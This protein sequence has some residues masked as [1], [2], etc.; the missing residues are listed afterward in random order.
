M[1][2]TGRSPVYSEDEFDTNSPVISSRHGIGTGPNPFEAMPILTNPVP[3]PGQSVPVHANQRSIFHRNKSLSIVQS[4]PIRANPMPTFIPITVNSLP[5]LRQHR[6]TLQTQCQSGLL[7]L[8]QFKGHPVL[9]L[10]QSRSCNINLEHVYT[11]ASKLKVDWHSNGKGFPNPGQSGANFMPFTRTFV[12][13]T[14]EQV[15]YTGWSL[16]YSE[17]KIQ[18]T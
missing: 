12:W 1:L 14:K 17:D 2:Y 6:A 18:A 5:I 9:H 15:F 4:V 13:I 16:A 8:R 7:L 11:N 10:C 3:I